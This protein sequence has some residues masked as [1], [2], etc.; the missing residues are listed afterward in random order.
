MAP[1]HRLSAEA[2][3][4]PQNRRVVRNLEHDARRPRRATQGIRCGVTLVLSSQPPIA[5]KRHPTEGTVGAA[6]HGLWGER[7]GE[8]D[9]SYVLA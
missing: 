6:V 5:L 1:C 3:T 8:G 2:D 4:G 7:A 9:W